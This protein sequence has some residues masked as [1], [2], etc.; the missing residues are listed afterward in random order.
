MRGRSSELT[1]RLPIVQYWDAGEPPSYLV[2]PMA[3]FRDRNPE[4]EHLLFDERTAAEFIA[5]RIGEREAAAFRSCAVPTMQSD[6]FRY[7]AVHA[8]GGVY[9]DVGFRC[10]APLGSL[11]ED[12]GGGRVFRVEPPGYLLSGFFLYDAPGHPLPRLV[13]DVATTNIE[14]RASQLV[15]MVT[16]PWIHSALS[17]LHRLGSLEVYRQDLAEEGL[18]RLLEPF[19]REA[20]TLAPTPAA[21]RAI[22][23]MAAPLFEAVGDYARVAEAFERVRVTP[24]A[25]ASDWVSAPESSLPYKESE[26]YWIN[27]QKQRSIFK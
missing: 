4:M 8:L 19:C 27:W 5:E 11:L 23:P 2:E 14:R 16:G 20:A 21:R 1:Q 25:M 12:L 26:R 7:C 18:G 9:A 24:Y 10:L 3:T 22:A 17:V 6:Y 15:Q 13:I